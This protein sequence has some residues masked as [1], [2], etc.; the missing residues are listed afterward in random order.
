MYGFRDQTGQYKPTPASSFSTTVTQGAASML[1][2]WAQC[3]GVQ[4][5]RVQEAARGRGGVHHQRTGAA[6]R[7]VGN[8]GVSMQPGIFASGGFSLVCDIQ[9]THKFSGIQ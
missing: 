1:I 6:V 3:G 8:R 9:I 2:G 5:H 4:V 7:A